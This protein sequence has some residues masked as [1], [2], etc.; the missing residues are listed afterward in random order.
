MAEN[1]SAILKVHVAPKETKELLTQIE[2]NVDTLADK[3]DPTRKSTSRDGERY[4]VARHLDA[5][6]KLAKGAREH[7]K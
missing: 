4:L 5:I 1:L 7:L 3:L 2:N 6:Y